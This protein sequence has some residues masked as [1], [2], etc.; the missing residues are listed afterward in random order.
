M[1]RCVVFPIPF[2]K[3]KVFKPQRFIQLYPE[4][5]GLLMGSLTWHRLTPELRHLH[6]YGCRL[7]RRMNAKAKEKDSPKLYC[8]AYSFAV[9]DVRQLV[10]ADNLSQVTSADV[11]HKIEDGEVAHAEIRIQFQSNGTQTAI[12]GTKTAIVD[13]LWNASR[14]ALKHTCACDADTK[15]HP[16]ELLHAGP[17]GEYVDKRSRAVRFCH[18]FRFWLEGRLLLKALGPELDR[19]PS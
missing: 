8:G 13:R 2:A 18:V 19:Q 14:G 6:G 15:P 9:T 10:G 12:T 17:R 5:E 1:F 16:S 3:N 7:A 4:G 11:I